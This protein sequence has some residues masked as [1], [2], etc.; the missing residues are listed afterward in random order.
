M[1][2]MARPTVQQPASGEFS[3]GRQKWRDKPEPPDEKPGPSAKS[4]ANSPPATP[5]KHP[6]PSPRPPKRR[7]FSGG[8]GVFQTQHQGTNPS[9]L[10]K[11]TARAEAWKTDRPSSTPGK[12]PSPPPRPPKRAR[13]VQWK[14][15][16][17]KTGKGGP[18][19]PCAMEVADL[20]FALF[21]S[22]S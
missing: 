15:L 12:H 1:E 10:T 16:E 9:L 13:L 19:P 4:G 21:C 3:R 5:G 11:N 17:K 20:T 8:T 18:G 7:T 14:R 2:G 22:R 6:S